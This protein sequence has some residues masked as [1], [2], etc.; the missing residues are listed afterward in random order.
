MAAQRNVMG[1][2]AQARAV[3]EPGD[4][5]EAGRMHPIPWSDD[6]S[7]RDQ[8]APEFG[9]ALRGYD[10]DQVDE[11]VAWMRDYAIQADDRAARAEAALAQCRRELA[12]SPTTAGISERLAAMLQLATEE[13]AEIRARARA[14]ADVTVAE[15]FA[16]AERTVDES[17]ALRD[18]I[19]R[20][21][22]ELS[23]TRE[24]LLQRLIEL[25]GEVLGAT[26]RFR[27]HAPGH[28]PIASP[29]PKLYDAEA[30][31]PAADATDAG[32]VA[33]AATVSDA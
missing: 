2:K 25:G 18:A 19:Q 28:A 11:Y 32:L 24:Q 5:V 27:G 3:L 17:N 10:R 14:D 6:M 21:I 26:E 15:A 20:E 12:S 22:D 30:D 31:A 8:E 1:A 16:H 23:E 33:E 13:A 29:V 9:H 4:L 7:M